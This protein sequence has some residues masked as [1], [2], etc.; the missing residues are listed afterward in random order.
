MPVKLWVALALAASVW[1]GAAVARANPDEIDCS[2]LSFTFEPAGNA[3]E[4]T[5]YR[6]SNSE[7][8][9]SD[10][11]AQHT[12]VYE[13]MFVY[14]GAEV[15]RITTGRA[16][17]NVYF[18]RRP[19]KG[20]VDMFDELEDVKEW[21]IQAAY[22]DYEIAQF[23]AVL[24]REPAVC[25]GF[26]AVGGNVIGSRGSAIGPGSFT[27]GYDCQFGTGALSRSLIEQTLGQID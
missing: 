17:E 12:A 2:R 18:T 9:G 5:C 20:Y 13:H 11:S 27:V 6:I 23:S 22:D 26:L 24:E 14:Q 8:S 15:I 21:N 10:G 19:L 7:A 25:F 1:G 16:V 4:A 3:D